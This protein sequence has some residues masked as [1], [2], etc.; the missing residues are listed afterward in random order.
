MGLQPWSEKYPLDLLKYWGQFVEV[1]QTN[2]K[3]LLQ[4]AGR[5]GEALLSVFK[6]TWEG[7]Q[8]LEEQVDQL[9]Q[10]LITEKARGVMQQ[11][12]LAAT[13]AA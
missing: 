10:E 5:M 2:P 4:H 3:E 1:P 6:V 8:E 13:Q 7:L 12:S 9:K 11:Q